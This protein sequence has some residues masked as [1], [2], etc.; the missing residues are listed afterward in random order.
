MTNPTEAA[1]T[2]ALTCPLVEAQTYREFLT[3][4]PVGNLPGH[5]DLHV[6][7]TLS[8]ARVP[9]GTQTKHR[10]TLET[11]AL[12]RLHRHLGLYLDAYREAASS[13]VKASQAEDA[14]EG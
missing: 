9:N 2:T 8:T 4:A 5:H 3:L 6:Q 13:L 7:S 11:P 12:E 1:S 10:L 14:P